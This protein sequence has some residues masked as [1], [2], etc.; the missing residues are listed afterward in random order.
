MNLTQAFFESANLLVLP[1]WLLLIVFPRASWT[2]RIFGHPRFGPPHLFALLY[3]L[4]VIPAVLGDPDALGVLMRPTLAGVQ[5]LLGSPG[6]AAAGWI[7]YLCFDLFVGTV[8]WRSALRRE[9]SFRWVSPVLVLVLM[10][11]PLGW[12]AYEAAS[13]I[14]IGRDGAR[15]DVG[16]V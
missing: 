16:W 9:Q 12:L 11:G 8:I 2:R 7:H 5:G 3:V 13:W 15:D 6:G 14:A 10:V 1:C 4:A